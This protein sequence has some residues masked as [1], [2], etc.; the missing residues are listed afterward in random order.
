MIS[1]LI[2]HQIQAGNYYYTRIITPCVPYP[3]MYLGKTML[4]S[5][6]YEKLTKGSNRQSSFP[7]KG[8]KIDVFPQDF[9]HQGHVYMFRERFPPLIEIYAEQVWTILY[10][11]SG[12][13]ARAVS[14]S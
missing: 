5:G 12:K 1:M 7:G 3:W 14:H 13:H 10:P 6:A 4:P 11:N 9:S 2:D 8:A